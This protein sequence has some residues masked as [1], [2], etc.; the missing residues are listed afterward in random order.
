MS[1]KVA[2]TALAFTALTNVHAAVEQSKI[3]ANSLRTTTAI[4]SSIDQPTRP[5]L[6]T[7]ST[8][9]TEGRS[10]N[11]VAALEESNTL[12]ML[13]AGLAIMGLVVRRRMN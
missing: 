12:G 11:P 10:N 13:L 2:V 4:S 3:Q 6:M 5:K 9:A 8:V 1:I 7:T